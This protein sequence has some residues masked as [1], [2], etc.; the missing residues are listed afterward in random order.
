MTRTVGLERCSSRIAVEFWFAYYSLL[1]GGFM[2][3]IR[4]KTGGKRD[5]PLSLAPLSLEEAISGAMRI[6]LPRALKK[7]K[8]Q[9]KASKGKSP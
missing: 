8:K 5:G 1:A 4:R 9:K 3:D 7:T 2:A 6:T